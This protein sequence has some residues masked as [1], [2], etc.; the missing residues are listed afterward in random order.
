M[1]TTKPPLDPVYVESLQAVARRYLEMYR[2]YGPESSPLRERMSDDERM[3]VD[4][5]HHLRETMS[6]TALIELCEAWLK[7]NGQKAGD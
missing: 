2:T 7:L 4:Y 3:R 5:W 6:A 1:I